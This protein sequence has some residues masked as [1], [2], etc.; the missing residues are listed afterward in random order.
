MLTRGGEALPNT[1]LSS[2]HI[3]MIVDLRLYDAA[4]PQGPPVALP[5]GV[6]APPSVVPQQPPVL[7]AHVAPPA[8]HAIPAQAWVPPPSRIPGAEGLGRHVL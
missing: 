7:P 3:L 4:P 5:Q 1:Q 8:T 6:Y 2:D